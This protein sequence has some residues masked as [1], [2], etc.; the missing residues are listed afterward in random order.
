MLR[1]RLIRLPYSCPI[2]IIVTDA[3]PD[4]LEPKPGFDMS[5]NKC[6]VFGQGRLAGWLADWLAGWLA[7]AAWLAGPGWASPFKKGE[8]KS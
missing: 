2:F 7:L 4:P 1:N 6:L 5:T 3:P 8:E